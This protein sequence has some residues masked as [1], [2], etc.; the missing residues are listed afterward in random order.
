MNLNICYVILNILF[1]M[2]ASIYFK[3]EIITMKQ[4]VIL[5]GI[6]LFF[7]LVS[8]NYFNGIMNRIFEL[9]FLDV[10]AYLLLLIVTH[11]IMLYTINRFVKLRYKIFNYLLFFFLMILCGSVLS[12]AL[13]NHF[14]RFYLMD[15]GNAVNFIDLSFVIFFI[16]LIIIGLIYIGSFVLNE[17]GNKKHLFYRI[18]LPHIHLKN[19]KLSYIRFNKNKGKETIGSK[20]LILTPEEVLKSRYQDGFYINGEEC[21]IIFDDSNQDN[22]V[23]NY[24]ILN[25]DIHARLMNGFT[26]EENRLLKSICMKLHV[27]SL[28]SIDF[29]NSTLLNSISVD[30]YNLLK[31]VFG[32]N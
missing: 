24:Y 32:V 27:G 9:K 17:N 5:F 2:V 25:Q 19:L 12:V 11:I 26:L 18:K 3:D 21:S 14:E 15:V 31:K 16:Y 30:E 8:G 20:D 29:G 10:K 28:H 1:L 7:T 13:G 4:R 23:K 22:I 6:Y